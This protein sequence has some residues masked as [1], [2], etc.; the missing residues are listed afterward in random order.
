MSQFFTSGGQSIGVSASASVLPVNIQLVSFR[1]DWF[2]LLAVQGTLS[3]KNSLQSKELTRT[4]YSLSRPCCFI[5]PRLPLR[6]AFASNAC[7]TPLCPTNSFLSSKTCS[8]GPS[9]VTPC[10]VGPSVWVGH[11]SSGVSPHSECCV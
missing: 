4:Y 10:V 7:F 2:D 9:S 11:P 3:P 6:G 5:L 1:I 8:D